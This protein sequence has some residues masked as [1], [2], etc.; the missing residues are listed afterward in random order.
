MIQKQYNMHGGRNEMA[1]ANCNLQGNKKAV[2]CAI[3]SRLKCVSLVKYHRQSLM[4][5]SFFYQRDLMA[6]R[7]A[8]DPLR[9][10]VESK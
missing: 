8:W 2:P 5:T 10:G 7:L 4:G 3:T 1:R 9:S 6:E